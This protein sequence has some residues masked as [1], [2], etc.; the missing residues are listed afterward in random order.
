MRVLITVAGHLD[1]YYDSPIPGE[2]QK[3]PTLSLLAEHDFDQLVILEQNFSREYGQGL[4]DEVSKSLPKLHVHR[5]E[6]ALSS[7]LQLLNCEKDLETLYLRIREQFPKAAIYFNLTS[8]PPTFAAACLSLIRQNLIRAKGFEVELSPRLDS[9]GKRSRCIASSNRILPPKDAEEGLHEE[10]EPFIE[11]VARSL[12]CI[13]GEFHFR[14]ALETAGNLARH[15]VPILLQGEGGVGKELFARIIHRLS[16][17]KHSPLVTVNCSTL[18]ESMAE[19]ILFGHAKGAFP[20]TNERMQGKVE[21]ADGSTLFLKHVEALPLRVQEKLKRGPTE[22]S[23]EP[24]GGSRT[25]KVNVRM[26]V[27]TQENLIAEITRGHFLKPL[28]QQLQAGAI[29]I[30]PLRKRKGDIPKLALHFLGQINNSLKTPKTIS[31]EALQ[32]LSGYQWRGNVRE[33]QAVIERTVLLSHSHQITAKELTQEGGAVE[34]GMED[35]PDLPV[36]DDN[37]SLEAYLGGIRKR[38]I[39]KALE[40]SKGN[41]S[42]AARLLKL[43]PQAVHQFLKIR[44]R[45]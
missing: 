38:I 5:M 33:L 27:S 44:T 4:R 12:G 15:N 19:G 11:E 45:K 9:R 2:S 21:L 13:G 10:E 31:R 22:A 41:Q 36:L 14:N 17:R 37:F 29:T 25:V 42:E 8:M 7:T 40:L 6:F 28:Y 32:A 24:L 43:T 3:G 1:P 26:I 30:P 16:Q 23:I 39:F 34:S 18:P 35:L 20:G